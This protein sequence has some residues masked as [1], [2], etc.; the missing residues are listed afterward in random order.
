MP[1]KKQNAANGSRS[2]KKPVT[3]KQQ[4]KKNAGKISK[5]APPPDYLQAVLDAGNIGIWEWNVKKDILTWHG[6]AFDHYNFGG[7]LPT[8]LKTFLEVI[9][10][11]DKL[12][13]SQIIKESVKRKSSYH[14]DYR[15]MRSDGSVVWFQ[16]NGM[17]LLNK[18]GSISKVCGTVQD[19][20]AK[21]ITDK[22]RDDWKIRHELISASAGMVIYDYDIASGNILWSGSSKEVLGFAPEELGHINKWVAMIHPEDRDDAFRKLELAQE[23]LQPYDVYY[24][25][26]RDG[27]HVHIHD[28]GLFIAEGSKA[29]RMLGIM[30]DVTERIKSEEAVRESELRFRTLQQAS[31]GGIGLHD[32]GLILDC[33]QGLSELTGYSIEELIGSNGV[34]LIAPEWR[35]FVKEKII[36]RYD[37]TY[38][39]EGIRKDGS[40]YYLEIR[41]K[42]IPYEDRTI[43][44]TE[45][46]DISDRKQSEQTIL[47][48]NTKLVALTDDLRRKNNQLEEFTQI[49][50][51]NLRSPV[52][53]ILTLLSFYEGAESVEEKAEYIGLLRESATTTL[54]MLN[55]L[56]EVLKIKQNKNIEK[57]SL[58]FDSVLTQIVS[59]LN[60]KVTQVSATIQSDFSEAPLIDYPSI[61]LESI[62]LNLLDNALKYS[63]PLRKPIIQLKTYRTEKGHLKLEVRDNG[64]GI[65]MDRY[66][67]QIFKLRKTFHHHP[68][69]RGIGLFMVKNQIEAMGG[70]ITLSSK[71]HEG[72]TFFINFNKHQSDGF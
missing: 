39:V 58:R 11:D 21:K 37:K 41:G 17:V 70:E 24:R 32:R 57:Q 4:Q 62:L 72:T 51:H 16:T 64:I 19:V 20:T 38:D 33:N 12:R 67:H 69:G 30:K 43:R 47:E 25:F 61:Y 3:K 44:V 18:N 55:E 9:H 8:S 36:S 56:N 27:S 13:V 1:G 66:K 6:K 26:M 54:T 34:D 15:I 49:V 22:E 48:Q 60:A 65:N 7:G 71:E 52:G 40:R 53:N 29:K 28:H 42:N 45:F 31:F 2:A 5:P 10:P 46:R 23:K 68:E 14:A 63:S 50:S 35:D 59:M